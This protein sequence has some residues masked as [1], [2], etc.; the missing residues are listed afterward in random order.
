M[1]S[2]GEFPKVDGD[3]LFASEVNNF[4]SRIY[5]VDTSGDIDTDIPSANGEAEY[6][7]N[8]DTDNPAPD[9]LSISLLATF[10]SKQ[11]SENPRSQTDLRLQAKDIGGEYSTLFEQRM[12]FTNQHGSCDTDNFVQYIHELT[13]DEKANGMMIKVTTSASGDGSASVTNHQTILRGL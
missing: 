3:V 1:A 10:Y 11:G 2:E 8:W 9:Y 12:T 6:T 4:H 13:D 7:L 5:T